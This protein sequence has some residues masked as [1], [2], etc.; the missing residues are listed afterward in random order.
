[1]TIDFPQELVEAILDQLADESASLKA[2]SLVCRAWVSRSRF[3][4]FET[5]NL[6]PENILVFRDLLRSHIACTFAP[7]IRR[8]TAFRDYSHANDDCFDTIAVD[9]RRLAHIRTLEMTLSLIYPTNADAYFR[10]G[11]VTAFQYITRLSF[12]CFFDSFHAQPVPLIE[13]LCLFPA[14]QELVVRKIFCTIADPPV[15]AVLPRR[16]HS[17]E[18][19]G[20]SAGPILACLQAAGHLPNVDSLTLPAM[21][22]HH[23]T[24]TVRAAL[25]QLGSSLCHLDI[26]MTSALGIFEVDL[27]SGFDFTLLTLETLTIRTAHREDPAHFDPNQMIRLITRL[28]GPALERLSLELDPALYRNVYFDWAALDEFLTPTR[29]PRLRSVVFK[30]TGDIGLD[31][32]TFLHTVLPLLEA[33]GV[34]RTEW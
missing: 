21:V 25:Q 6:L 16:L 20:Q 17:V 34:L 14:L 23:Q 10:A 26:M 28:P 3:H 8:I 15:G 33:S 2:C 30:C 19:S 12:S 24:E 31:D 5:C 1:M 11:F 9:L 22:N 18:L 29:F 4:L 32:L 27:F 7:Q 13:M